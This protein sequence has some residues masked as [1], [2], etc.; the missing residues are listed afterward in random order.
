MSANGGPHEEQHQSFDEE[1]DHDQTSGRRR[2]G[3]TIVWI[4]G[5][6]IA[7]GLI[8]LMVVLHTTGVMGPGRH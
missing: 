3:T 1:L 5:I 2:S 4:G 8:V 6:V 7:V